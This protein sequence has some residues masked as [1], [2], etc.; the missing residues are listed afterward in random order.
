[1]SIWAAVVQTPSY[2]EDLNLCEEILRRCV[3]WGLD[4]IRLRSTSLLPESEAKRGRST[5]SSSTA[6]GVSHEA[7]DH[8]GAQFKR[9]NT[10]APRCESVR[11]QIIFSL[12]TQTCRSSLK[13]DL[14]PRGPRAASREKK[15]KALSQDSW[16]GRVGHVKTHFPNTAAD[17]F[18]SEI[19]NPI[20]ISSVSSVPAESLIVM[21][22]LT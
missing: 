17:A 20:P 3:E 19:L 21:L 12:Q 2:F 10:R 15:S 1:M 8:G 16:S 9:E 18:Q 11:S 4:V 22:A 6:Q 13:R 14:G 5:R 7:L